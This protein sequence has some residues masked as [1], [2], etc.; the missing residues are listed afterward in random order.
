MKLFLDILS[1]L[2]LLVWP[3]LMMMSP[4][5]F[6]APGSENNKSNLTFLLFVIFYPVI[7]FVCYK[8]FGMTYF[9]ISADRALLVCVV[10]TVLVA[11]VFGYPRFIMNVVAGIS[12]NGYFVKEDKVYY[13]GKPLNSALASTFK[14]IGGQYARYALDEKHVYFDGRLI[15]GADAGSFTGVSN[16]NAQAGEERFTLFW[17][18]QAH[19]YLEGR[20]LPGAKAA[21]FRH[22]G[23]RYGSD[24]QQVYYGW[25][26]LQGG[27][28]ASFQLLNPDMGKDDKQVFVFDKACKL[29]APTAHFHLLSNQD[30]AVYATDGQF[31]YAVFFGAMEPLQVVTDA[32][33]ATFTLLERSYFKDNK[34]VYYRDS[35]QKKVILLEA[36][37]AAGFVAGNYDSATDSDAH[38]GAHYYLAGKLATGKK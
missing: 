35:S 38:D 15:E 21:E 31:L 6:D 16:P 27:N 11:L 2:A 25:Q 3:L 22:L 23:G 10:L 9:R 18:D 13:Y 26:V 8:L 4:M 14:T 36:A 30:L 19:V 37:D 17:K 28:P 1:T 7:I 24:N 12:G 32:D 5:L 34:R 29:N 20:I 33:P